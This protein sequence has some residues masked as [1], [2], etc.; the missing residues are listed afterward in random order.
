MA[1]YKLHAYCPES[2]RA[3]VEVAGHGPFIY[4][5]N[6]GMGISCTYHRVD[7][8]APLSEVISKDWVEMNEPYY[9]LAALKHFVDTMHASYVLDGALL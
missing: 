8:D 3:L 1:P 9:T 2:S 4:Q 7:L 6:I 5:F